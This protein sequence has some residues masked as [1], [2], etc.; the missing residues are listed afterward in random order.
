MGSMIALLF[1]SGDL[2]TRSGLSPPVF[3]FVIHAQ[4]VETNPG[5][6]LSVPPSIRVRHQ[7]DVL[8]QI[9]VKGKR[10][11]KE[12]LFIARSHPGKSGS[13]VPMEKSSVVFI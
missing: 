11:R 6:V 10:A 8:F 7:G 3:L 1:V 4:W 13:C 5:T 12:S 2:E 9:F